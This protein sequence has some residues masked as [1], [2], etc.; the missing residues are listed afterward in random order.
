MDLETKIKATEALNFL[1]EH[2]ALNNDGGD[3]LF[4]GSWF[5]ME[6]CCKNGITK[7]GG[8]DGVT[9][10]KSNLNWEKYAEYFRDNEEDYLPTEL[11]SAKVPYEVVYGEP[12]KADHME[13]WYEICFCVFEGDPYSKDDRFDYTKWARYG[14]PE[15]GANSFEEM[16]IKAAAEVKEAYGNFDSYQSFI[17]PSEK[18]NHMNVPPMTFEPIP[19]KPHYSTGIFNHEYQDVSQGL[20]NLRWLRWF[21]TT[22]YAKKNW[23]S[24]I[25]EWQNFV[26]KIETL[27]PEARK[28]ILAKY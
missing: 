11:H 22:D 10:W 18:N 9:I 16:L 20:T 12:W 26:A 1:R 2:P 13:Y 27:E 28:Q 17:T 3:S 14:G 8:D 21:I 15:G 23:E 7:W 24:N 19:E 25:P 5:H 4:N 6:L